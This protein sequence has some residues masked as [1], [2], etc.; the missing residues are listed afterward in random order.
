MRESVIF[1]AI[2]GGEIEKGAQREALSFV[3]RLLKRCFGTVKP[4]I[5]AQLQGLSIEQLEELGEALFDVSGEA[6][7]VNGLDSH[8]QALRDRAI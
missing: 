7:L 2:E 8:S 3:S 4:E 6:D 5:Q 1:Q